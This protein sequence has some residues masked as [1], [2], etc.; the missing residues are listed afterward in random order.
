[1]PTEGLLPVA[2]LEASVRGVRL[3]AFCA[4]VESLLAPPAG[5][6]GGG[7]GDEAAGAVGDSPLLCLLQSKALK[8]L[9]RA[10]SGGGGAAVA[11]ALLGAGQLPALLCCAV[12]PLNLSISS[13]LELPVCCLQGGRGGSGAMGGTRQA[14]CV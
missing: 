14:A 3:V 6:D 11:A 5:G 10:L 7:G 12:T 1:M 8:A 2:E 13:K 9:S 4:A